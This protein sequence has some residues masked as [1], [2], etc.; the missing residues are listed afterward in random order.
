MPRSVIA[1]GPDAAACLARP[2]SAV[3]SED[4]NAGDD[5]QAVAE[6]LVQADRPGDARPAVQPG[7]ENGHDARARGTHGQQGLM[8]QAGHGLPVGPV[9]E[10]PHVDAEAAVAGRGGDPVGMP[11]RRAAAGTAPPARRPPP[12]G[13]PAG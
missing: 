13:W 7:H 10:Q 5:Q 3:L 4:E 2:A 9:G 6:E 8:K 1:S 11:G 12:S